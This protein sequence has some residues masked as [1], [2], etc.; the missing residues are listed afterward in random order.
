M[1]R[2][3]VSG[4]THTDCF[5]DWEPIRTFYT[6]AAQHSGQ[7]W[8]F[9]DGEAAYIACSKVIMFQPPL[10]HEE[11]LLPSLLPWKDVFMEA[12]EFGLSK[13]QQDPWMLLLQQE[14]SF[15]DNIAC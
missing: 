15:G 6:A 13:Q 4:L 8:L 10:L 7:S 14:P 5:F 9:G 2:L 3:L 1:C 11:R 12:G